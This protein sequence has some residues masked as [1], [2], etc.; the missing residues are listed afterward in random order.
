M[1]SIFETGK[2]DS[3][4]SSIKISN[5]RDDGVLV[6]LRKF[7]GKQYEEEVDDKIF[8]IW[9]NNLGEKL[10]FEYVLIIS[11]PKKSN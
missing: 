2:G 5:I 4:E 6:A 1:Q 7:N 10:Y 8:S 3:Y 11:L 9:Q